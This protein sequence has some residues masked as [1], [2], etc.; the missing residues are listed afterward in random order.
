M[1]NQ[2][3][4]ER[5]DDHDSRDARMWRSGLCVVSRRA[6]DAYAVRSV[7]SQDAKAIAAL[8]HLAFLGG[9]DEASEENISRK[10]SAILAG[11]YGRFIA[12]ASFGH[13]SPAGE[14]DAAILVTDYAPYGGPVIALV[15]VGKTVQQRGIGTT[16]VANSLAV[17][18]QLGKADCC[19]RITDGNL[20]SER[21]FQVC[22]F[23]PSAS[24]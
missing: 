5:V 24:G 17:L 20:C 11:S 18:Q 6:L 21:L 12:A 9:P 13:E 7:R 1:K 22:G 8:A 23:T 2:N 4:Q 10:V 3:R 15:V 16:L 19:A 14:L